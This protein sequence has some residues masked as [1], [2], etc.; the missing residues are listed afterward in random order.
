M[1]RASTMIELSGVAKRYRTS[2]IETTVFDDLSLTISA[3]DLLVITGES[4][5]GKSTL[6]NVLGLIEPIDAGA[7]RFNGKLLDASNRNEVGR[8]RAQHFGFVFQSF[9]LVNRLRVIDNVLLPIRCIRRVSGEDR[10]KASE[11]LRRVGLE[12]RA[13]HYPNQL[14]G[15]QQ[16]RA[17]FA[18][19]LITD[20]AIVLADEPTGNLDSKTSGEIV[21]LL[22]DMNSTGTTIVIATHSADVSAV[23]RRVIELIDGELCDPQRRAPD[24]ISEA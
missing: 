22:G 12:Q 10:R 9:H 4:G 23:G 13:R 11:L 17:A 5:S 19:A 15:G 6:L 20:P 24:Q 14:S 8:L 7:Y 16:Q 21:A 3:G 18:R 2:D 1:I